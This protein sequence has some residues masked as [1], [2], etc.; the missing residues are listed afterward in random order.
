MMIFANQ[1]LRSAVGAMR[2]TLQTMLDSQC[3][4][5][6]NESIVPLKEIYRLV[7]VEAL[8]Q[9]ERQFLPSGGSRMKAVIIAAGYEEHLMPLIEDRP[10]CMLEIRGQTI[11]DSQVGSLNANGIKDISVVRGYKKEKINLP[12]LTYYNNDNYRDTGELISLFLAEN[13]LNDGFIF[14]YSDILFDQA[15]V[16]K[17]LNCK[18]DISLV[19][20]HSWRDSM[21][22]RPANAPSPDLV[23]MDED[24]DASYRFL[25]TSSGIPISRIGH[26]IPFE[27][28]NGEFIGMAMFTSDGVKKLKEIFQQLSEHEQREGAVQVHES[29][30]LRKAAFTDIIQVLVNGGVQVQAVPIYKGWLEVDTFEDYQRAWIKKKHD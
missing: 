30:T 16:E 2:E 26:T 12:N 14:L 4:K 27:E 6:V 5:P 1:A 23:V 11:L 7:G 19:V 22:N 24:E 25:P 3:I 28:A 17:L 8:Q 15:I 13:Q 18:A 9:N 20:D 21:H 29:E 10:K